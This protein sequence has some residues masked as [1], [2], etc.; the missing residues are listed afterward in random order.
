MHYH[1]KKSEC[2]EEQRKKK[3]SK[4]KIIFYVIMRLRYLCYKTFL[5]IFNEA[6]QWRE[7]IKLNLGKLRNKNW[8]RDREV[9][10]TSCCIHKKLFHEM[11]SLILI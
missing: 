7:K 4:M 5:C 3:I 8:E 9:S 1:K 2:E 10:A 11:R 6:V